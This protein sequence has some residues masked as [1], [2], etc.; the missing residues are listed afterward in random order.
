MAPPTDV[1]AV[2]VSSTSLRVS[3]TSPHQRHINGINQGYKVTVTSAGDATETVHVVMSNTSN[4]VGRQTGHVTGL[5]KFKEYSISVLC[6]TAK[7]D[8]P[9]SGA[10]K[11]QTLEDG[12]LT[13]GV[14]APWWVFLRDYLFIEG[15]CFGW[16]VFAP[17]V[18]SFCSWALYKFLK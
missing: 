15:C 3:W 13:F 18:C 14:S 2:P 10:I 8:G 4:M 5:R 7:G 12:K 1:Q 17:C 6:F 11:A 16:G 9:K